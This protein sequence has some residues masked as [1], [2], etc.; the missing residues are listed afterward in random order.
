MK[1]AVPVW[2]LNS[3]LNLNRKLLM[4]QVRKIVLSLL[5]VIFVLSVFFFGTNE[6]ADNSGIIKLI[7]VAGL[8]RIDEE[9]LVGL[10][11]FGIGDSLD[12]RKLDESI[13]RVFK[14]EMFLDVKVISEPLDDGIKLRLVVKEIPLIKRIT[15]EGNNRYSIKQIKKIFIYKQGDNYLEE[16]R[17]Q[18]KLSIVAFYERK[19]YI[20]T[21]V[22]IHVMP[23]AKSTISLRV[24][25]DEGQPEFISGLDVPAEVRSLAT[26][27]TGDILDKDELDKIISK[28]KQYYKDRDYIRPVVGPYRF[29][30]GQLIIPV[31]KG[32]R[33][34]LKFENNMAISA[35]ELTNEV[36]YVDD[37]EISDELTAEI[38]GRLK[39]LYMSKGY[40]YAQVAAG[41]ESTDE[42]VQVT[43]FIFEGKKV[44]LKKL[45]FE[46]ISIDP[47]TL[48]QIVPLSANQPFDNN[49]IKASIDSLVRFYNALGYLKI[50]V[51]DVKKRF[52]EEGTELDLNFVINEGPQIKIRE[53]MIYNNKRFSEQEIREAL[54]LNHDEPYNVVDI[55]DARYRL[56]SLYNRHGYLD[57]RVEIE[58][59]IILDNAFLTFNIDENRPSRTGKIILSGNNKTKSKI[60]N[61]EITIKE[62][63]PYNYEE[64][65]KIKQRLYK[66]GIFNEVSI[67]ALDP[68]HEDEN[69]FVR[70]VLVSLK[71][72]NDAAVEVSIGYGDY[73]EFRGSFDI[74][75]SNLGGY[76]RQVGFRTEL[77]DVEQRYV[78]SFKEPW[79]FNQPYVPLNIYFVREQTRSVNIETREVLYKLDKI[80]FIA[81]IDKT[82]A[83]RWK[84]GLSYEYSF[85]DTKDVKK[86]VILSREDTGTLG[87]GS[88]SPSLFYDTRDN[89]PDPTSGSKNG[90]VVKFASAPF[91]SET[92]FVKVSFQSASYWRLFKN[93]VLAVSLRGGVAYDLE[94][95]EELPLIE[96]YFLGGRSTVRGYK[97]DALGPEGED[98]S[99]TG[100]NV[101]GLING[102][103]RFSL[104]KGFGLVTFV[105]G[106]NVWRTID[107]ISSELKYTVGA[108][109]RY[110]TP[111]GPIRVDYGH[112][113]DREQG[114]S[115]GEV[116][117]SIGHAF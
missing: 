53:I 102:E 21:N 69:G 39:R 64:A 13:R 104:A 51:P 43:F 105:D 35:K 78:L 8:T 109:L 71:E 90:I 48:R 41:V 25:I 82:L 112:K 115:N 66:L 79:L 4:G 9:E 76:N 57:A 81:S 88:V 74:T 19:G 12:M 62:G 6:A 91:L 107:N 52:N 101:F 15:V 3:D 32:P 111:V 86:G 47:R 17:E 18:A 84:A 49:L 93:I 83:K 65:E 37:E 110:R 77:S 33:L 117:F 89:P 92:E 95:T 97:H 45:L 94:D 60:I 72:G 56:L 5:P 38:V 10:M 68:L 99:P 24:E 14:K 30:D 23:A 27:S 96:R 55:G 87:I 114:Q 58:S 50:E 40:Y 59:E 116:H 113:L 28:I 103:L 73:E 70:D 42:A 36:T 29:A 26:L 85:T 7:E 54:Q 16:L 11:S 31:S 106:G 34:D 98:G 22:E 67:N 61:R 44:I 2:I 75:Y 108:G 100:G 63:M 46:G 1:L 80:S 20:N